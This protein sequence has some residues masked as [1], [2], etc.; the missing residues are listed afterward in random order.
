MSKIIQNAVICPDGTI[1]QSQH[2][3]DCHV[4]GDYMVDGG[5][6]Y[7]RHG[8]PVDGQPATSLVLTD[9]DSIDTIKKNLLWGTLGKDGKGP[10]KYIFLKDCETDHL[11]S[12]LE[13]PGLSS[14][15]RYVIECILESRS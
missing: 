1:L 10:L 12:I 2:R 5:K 8:T 11:E 14:L 4:H 9:D 15:H 7:L 13:V 3:H 6:D